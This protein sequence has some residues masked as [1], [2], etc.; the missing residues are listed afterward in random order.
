MIKDD[1]KL[2]K[3]MIGYGYELKP[4]IWIC[5]GVIVVGMV[6]CLVGD[7]ANNLLGMLLIMLAPEFLVQS[8]MGLSYPGLCQSSPKIKRL[9]TRAY[10]TGCVC[11]NLIGYA[12]TIAFVL[13][14]S[15]WDD[16]G[17]TAIGSKLVFIC[18]FATLSNLFYVFAYHWFWL[19]FGMYVVL[20]VLVFSLVQLFTIFPE[21]IS[22]ALGG[23]L[24]LLMILAMWWPINWFSRWTYKYPMDV[25]ALG[26]SA[27]NIK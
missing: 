18:F 24:G 10:A 8:F 13:I 19:S 16:R 12:M 27:R 23:G 3:K 14:T 11:L 2:L 26:A 9:Q 21:V 5:V 22:P 17:L 25:Y 1:L 20:L 7:M 6:N 4:M 15:L